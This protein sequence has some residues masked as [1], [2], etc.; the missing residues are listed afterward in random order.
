MQIHRHLHPVSI[1]MALAIIGRTVGGPHAGTDIADVVRAKRFEI[2]DDQGKARGVFEVTLD[3]MARLELPGAN[4]ATRAIVAAPPH[5]AI[6]ALFDEDC[7]TPARPSGFR[8][9]DT[10]SACCDSRPSPAGESLPT[11]PCP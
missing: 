1:L 10:R 11:S 7:V 6:V 9:G 8:T 2:V 4:G 5:G 3:G